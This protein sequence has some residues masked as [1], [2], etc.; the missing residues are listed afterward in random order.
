M[1]SDL[2]VRAVGV[3]ADWRE[4]KK[5]IASSKALKSKVN[6]RRESQKSRK[7]MGQKLKVSKKMSIARSLT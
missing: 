3:T 2:T 6:D 5:N 4:K 1:S 7:S